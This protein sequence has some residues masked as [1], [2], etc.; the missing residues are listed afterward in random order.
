MPNIVP[1]DCFIM[2]NVIFYCSGGLGMYRED[3]MHEFKKTTG[4]LNEAMI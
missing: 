4:E 1:T 3:E 2:P